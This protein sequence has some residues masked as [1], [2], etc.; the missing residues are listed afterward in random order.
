MSTE[1]KKMYNVRVGVKFHLGQNEDCS[2][3]DSTSHSSETL[4]QR[5]M[6]EGQYIRFWGRWRS[7]QSS[8]Y[9]AS[10]FLLVTR[11]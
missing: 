3:G 1:E 6:G 5:G 2:P 7:V 11:S 9:F 8:T 4:L 10:G